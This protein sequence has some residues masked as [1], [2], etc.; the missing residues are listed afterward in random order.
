MYVKILKNNS[1]VLL[2]FFKQAIQYDFKVNIKFK[3]LELKKLSIIKRSKKMKTLLKILVFVTTL[4]YMRS[5]VNA[6]T[7]TTSA[8]SDFCYS[9][10]DC[11]TALD[12]NR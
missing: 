8:T 10:T 6:Q 3:N 9:C 2:D 12:S 4:N 5:N 7:T 1:T 11:T